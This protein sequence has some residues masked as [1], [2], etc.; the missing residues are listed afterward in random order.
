M[1]IPEAGRR[2]AFLLFSLSLLVLLSGGL[3]TDSMHDWRLG[4]KRASMEVSLHLLLHRR[5]LSPSSLPFSLTIHMGLETVAH[6]PALL[7]LHSKCSL[8]HFAQASGRRA[9]HFVRVSGEKRTFLHY[10]SLLYNPFLSLSLLHTWSLQNFGVGG[11]WGVG[12]TA[13]LYV[14][15]Y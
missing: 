7:H 8:L 13:L 4:Q 2:Q 3:E 1:I 5:G 10:P 15:L 6:S 9:L 12:G 14:P 11:F